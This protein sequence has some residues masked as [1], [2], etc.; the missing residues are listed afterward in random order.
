MKA[1]EKDVSNSSEAWEKLLENNLRNITLCCPHALAEE[2]RESKNRGFLQKYLRTIPKNNKRLVMRDP[3]ENE[4]YNEVNNIKSLVLKDPIE[5]ELINLDINIKINSEAPKI[6]AFG[7]AIQ[8]FV[9]ILCNLLETENSC[10]KFKVYPCG[11][12]PFN[13]KICHINEFDFRLEWLD[14]ILNN[15]PI[16]HNGIVPVNY[17]IDKM[18]EIHKMLGNI[19]H[20]YCSVFEECKVSIEFIKKKRVM[21]IIISWFCPFSDHQHEVSIDLAIC[22]K[23]DVTIG[24]FLA[25]ENPFKNSPFEV[26]LDKKEMIYINLPM[27]VRTVF[28]DTNS[29][30]EKLFKTCDIIS[31]NIKLCLRILKYLRDTIFPYRYKSKSADVF[32]LEPTIS[33]YKLKQLLLIEVVKFP[34]A[35]DWNLSLLHLRIKSILL[36]LQKAIHQFGFC[37]FFQGVAVIMDEKLLQKILIDLICWIESG[38]KK[39]NASVRCVEEKDVEIYIYG[40][41]LFKTKDVNYQHRYLVGNEKVRSLIKPKCLD[42]SNISRWLCKEYHDIVNSMVQV[43]LTNSSDP[44]ANQIMCMI[45]HKLIDE[46]DIESGVYKRKVKM[47][48][49]ILE[50][51]EASLE[52]IFPNNDEGYERSVSNIAQE[53]SPVYNR[54][55]L[56]EAADIYRYL[57]HKTEFDDMENSTSLSEVTKVFDNMTNVVNA[58]LVEESK[59]KYWLAAALNLINHTK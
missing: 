3:V 28:V 53:L 30:D 29:F 27:V 21:T 51:F 56:I 24:D 40:R 35:S 2:S 13:T 5:D 31:P 46:D 38:W 43:D 58:K 23:T 11:S 36:N 54:T 33:S 16:L 34:H 49:K 20:K 32:H 12:F 8:K 6:K 26:T 44:E 19:I 48:N 52:D 39:V 42:D 59:H 47:L 37:P 10:F 57:K 41:V 55:T 1:S 22:M 15:T 50:T 14:Q 18:S 9:E 45:I 4:F 25:I 7:Q 17:L